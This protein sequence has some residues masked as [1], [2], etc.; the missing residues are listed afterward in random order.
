MVAETQISIEN[1]QDIIAAA[2]ITQAFEIVGS[3]DLNDTSAIVINHAMGVVPKKV[4]SFFHTQRAGSRE[5][6]CNGSC[7]VIGGSSFFQ[8]CV[9]KESR[10]VAYTQGGFVTDRLMGIDD[11]ALNVG[12]TFPVTAVDIN[13]LTITPSTLN[14]GFPAPG[15]SIFYRILI[16]G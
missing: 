5:G 9:A 7:I 8:A 1:A 16:E 3:Q 15:D 12:I 13:N 10:I 14:G 4:F 2:G 6:T 11:N